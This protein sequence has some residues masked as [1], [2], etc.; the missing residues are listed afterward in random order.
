VG[1][2]ERRRHS[3][4]YDPTSNRGPGCDRLGEG[5]RSVDAGERADGQ[6]LGDEQPATHAGGREHEPWL[7]GEEGE[8]GTDP[9]DRD[10]RPGPAFGVHTPW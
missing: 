4:L 3:E 8:R 9:G 5:Q 6:R 2:V 7:A 10:D 1:L